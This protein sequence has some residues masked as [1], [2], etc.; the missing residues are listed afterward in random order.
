MSVTI[1]RVFQYAFFFQIISLCRS[2]LI[3]IYYVCIIYDTKPI[4]QN[5]NTPIIQSGFDVLK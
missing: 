3:T 5:L 1:L 4:E 2:K